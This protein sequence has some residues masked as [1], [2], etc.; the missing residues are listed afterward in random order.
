MSESISIL[1]ISDSVEVQKKFMLE[2]LKEAEKALSL[3]EIPVGCVFIKD[4]KIIG[5]GHNLTNITR[6]VF[7]SSFPCLLLNNTILGN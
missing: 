4:N 1:E 7:Y 5:R 6:N 2:A 3:S